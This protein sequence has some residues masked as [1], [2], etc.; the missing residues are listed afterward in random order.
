MVTLNFGTFPK[1][2]IQDGVAPV[3]KVRMEVI[4][5]LAKEQEAKG[6]IPLTTKFE[7]IMWVHLDIVKDEQWESSHQAQGQILQHLYGSRRWYRNSGFSE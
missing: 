5:P 6:L 4:K 2:T 7:E 1:V 3:P